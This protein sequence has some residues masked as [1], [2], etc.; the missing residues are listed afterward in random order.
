MTANAELSIYESQINLETEKQ[1]R[2]D[3]KKYMR[4]DEQMVVFNS[5][6]P[7]FQEEATHQIRVVSGGHD[8]MAGINFRLKKDKSIGPGSYAT[9]DE[10]DEMKSKRKETAYKQPPQVAFGAGQNRNENNF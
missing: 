4:Q 7:R 5:S 8:S 6:A 3:L 10:I 1:I 9:Y 2:E